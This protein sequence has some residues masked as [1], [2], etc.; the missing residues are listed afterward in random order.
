MKLLPDEIYES[1]EMPEVF[2]A[3][4]NKVLN[5]YQTGMDI[6][7]FAK[8]HGFE[9]FLF[10]LYKPAAIALWKS[11]VFDP[12]FYTQSKEGY[13]TLVHETMHVYDQHKDGKN[14]FFLKY[15]FPQALSYFGLFGMLGILDPKYFPL[16]GLFLLRF[17]PSKPRAKYELRALA[18]EMAVLEKILPKQKAK[19]EVEKRVDEFINFMHGDDYYKTRYS[20]KELEKMYRLIKKEI[21]LEP[22]YKDVMAFTKRRIK[23]LEKMPML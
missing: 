14:M 16:F 10:I 15:L 18:I 11:I 12:Y 4:K 8:A 9:R 20:K 13:I 1:P 17:V 21:M 3:F 6:I 22:I 2:R 7:P 19:K 23:T 5:K